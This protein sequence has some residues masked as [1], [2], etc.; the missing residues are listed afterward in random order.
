MKDQLQKDFDNSIKNLDSKTQE[1]LEKITLDIAIDIAEFLKQ[2]DKDILFLSKINLN[3]KVLKDFFDVKK[4]EILINPTYVY[5]DNTNIW[6]NVNKPVIN[7]SK[8]I[9]ILEDNKKEFN[10]ISPN[11]FEYKEIPIYKELSFFDL[12]G[13]EKYKISNINEKKLDISKKANTYINSENYFD[14]IQSLN[15]NEIFVSSVIGEYVGSKIIGDFTKEKAKKFDINFEPE[16][17]A[18]A[19]KENP[20]GKRFEGIVRFITPIFE[21]NNKIGYLSFALDHR[22]IM[23]YTDLKMEISNASEGNYAFMWDNLGRNI[24]HP[25]DYFIYGYDKNTGKNVTPWLS[26]DLYSEFIES[27]K[28]IDI[29]LKN[30]PQFKEQSLKKKANMNQ[31]IKDGILP[32]DCRYLNFAPQC[33]GWMELTK[34]G[35]HGSFIIFW[36]GV[37]KLTTAAAIPYYTGKYKESK[38]GFGFVTIGANVDEF[39]SAA[40]KTKDS[41]KEILNIQNNIVEEILIDSS[42]EINQNI[43]T[44]INELSVIT[45]IMVILIIFIAL[46]L[47][48]YISSKIEKLLIGTK[49]FSQNDFDYRIRVSSDDE[50]GNLEKS[51]NKMASKISKLI[52]EQNQLNEHLEE[53]VNE[54]TKE[55]IHIN[56]TLEKRVFKEVYENRKKDAQL[57]QASRMATLGEMI[58]MILHQ[59]KQPLTA[60]SMI[61]SSQ[62]LRILL[63][64]N[65]EEEQQKDNESLKKQIELMTNTMNDFRDFF[66]N[67]QKSEYDV[68][69]MIEKSINLVRNI[70]K[71]QGI[72]FRYE[73]TKDVK[74]FKTLGFGNELIQVLLNIFNNARDEIIKNKSENKEIIIDLYL[75]NRNIFITITD[76]AGGIKEDI[77]NNIFNAY[78]STKDFDKGTGLGLYMCKSIIEKV[79]GDIYIEDVYEE[80]TLQKGVKFVIKLKKEGN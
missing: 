76:F 43:K 75:N 11:K 15:E 39:H 52:F 80:Q 28:D 62:E 1:N 44:I 77:K 38:R 73:F 68:N 31:L 36:S 33:S 24:S 25:R 3:D 27:K 41:I 72:F 16:K 48:N 18:Y 54:K 51:F 61:V 79:D 20:V 2:V 78:F 9:N 71:Y 7:V 49:K 56:E 21:Q 17:Y 23:E 74:E 66:R 53:K 57:V 14:E 69:E 8:N 50:I 47:S 45:I 40:N 10:Y 12:K 55:L 6:E 32:L 64:K 60:I 34:D 59:W 67:T 70:F 22:H 4:K 37:W 19:G 35:G 63:N 46:L 29:F 42:N 58:S 26:E 65:S 5:N 13:I 30:Y